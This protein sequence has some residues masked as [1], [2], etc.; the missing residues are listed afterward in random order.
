[1]GTEKLRL[2]ILEKLKNT[3]EQAAVLNQSI[4]R[5]KIIAELCM[6][7]GFTQRTACSYIQTLLDAWFIREDEFGLWLRLPVQQTIEGSDK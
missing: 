2:T 4:S 7:Y 1:M 6:T 5:T 3:F